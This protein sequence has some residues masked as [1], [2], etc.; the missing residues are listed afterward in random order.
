MVAPSWLAGGG[1]EVGDAL[2]QRLVAGIGNMWKAEALWRA[3]VSPWRLVGET[4]DRELRAVLEEAARLMRAAVETGR[5]ERV[6]YRRAGRLCPRCRTPIE[7]RG[8]GDANRTV[9]W[10]PVCQPWKRGAGRPGA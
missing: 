9:Y 2:D 7:S 10:C 4:S 3:R 1:R 6:V 8:Q 5:E